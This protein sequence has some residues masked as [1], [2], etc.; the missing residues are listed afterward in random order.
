MEALADQ[1][2]EAEREAAEAATA[3]KREERRRAGAEREAAEAAEARD[4]ALA[5]VAQLSEAGAD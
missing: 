5:R 2:A 3:L 1:L 4:H